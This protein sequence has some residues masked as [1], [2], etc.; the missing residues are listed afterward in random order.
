MNNKALEMIDFKG[1]HAFFALNSEKAVG[2]DKNGNP[3]TLREEL[4][5]LMRLIM[6]AQVEE[7]ID[8]V[9]FYSKKAFLYV[10]NSYE[11]HIAHSN[12]LYKAAARKLCFL[13]SRCKDAA[14]DKKGFVMVKVDFDNIEICKDL[15]LAFEWVADN[16]SYLREA[17]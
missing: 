8:N 17:V 14:Q 13:S 15:C 16:A 9:S 1:F 11:E 6:K 7:T 5:A 2:V 4:S 3:N 12:N 10:E